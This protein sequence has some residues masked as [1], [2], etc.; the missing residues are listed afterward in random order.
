MKK[1]GILCAGIAVA[2]AAQAA[3]AQV[4]DTN[5]GLTIWYDARATAASIMSPAVPYTNGTS[6]QVGATA[7]AYVQAAIVDGNNGGPGDGQFLYI[8]PRLPEDPATGFSLHCTGT[9]KGGF[10]NNQSIKTLYKYATVEQRSAP[11]EVIGALGLDTVFAKQGTAGAGNRIENVGFTPNAALWNGNNSTVTPAAAGE[12][13]TW[14]VAAKA[15]KVPVAAGPTY[16]SS[17]GLI[18]SATPYQL[19]SY[20]ITA[21]IWKKNVSIGTNV[22]NTGNGV[23]T[24]HDGV[25]NLLVTRVYNGTGPSP[26]LPDF[27]YVMNL[28]A[29]TSGS[30][31]AVFTTG[32]NEE[33]GTGDGLDDTTTSIQPDA[34]IVIQTK[35][36]FN[37]S[38]TITALDIDGRTDAINASANIRIRELFLGDFDD[39]NTVTV[40]DVTPFN[41]YV[42]VTGTADCTN[43]ADCNTNCQP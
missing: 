6:V 25:N 33:A 36:D 13:D 41:N 43:P 16:N 34:T 37:N 31:G 10:K 28:T 12:S 27:G 20:T 38:G 40:L 26:E 4:A 24:V 39:T 11:D 9:K 5:N 2:F 7:K 19:G 22:P 35:G 18:P 23:Y 15:V 14:T 30:P 21:G 3:R 8:S 1:F 29:G 17:G 32:T 42:N